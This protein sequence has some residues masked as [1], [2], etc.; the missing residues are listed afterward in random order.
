MS[1]S[2]ELSSCPNCGGALAADA[3]E[4]LCAKCVVEVMMNFAN[5]DVGSFEDDEE[6]T[7][8][9]A[10]AQ[11]GQVGDYEILEKIAAGGMGV[12]YRAR[13]KSLGRVVALKL[14]TEGKLAADTDKERFLLEARAAGELDHPNIVPIYEVGEDDGQYF[15]SMPLR[16]VGVRRIG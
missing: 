5:A 12:V 3:P 13:Q 7:L 8:L 11:I 2:E 16:L 4:G 6:A 10:A 15:F 14:V 1:S 9:S